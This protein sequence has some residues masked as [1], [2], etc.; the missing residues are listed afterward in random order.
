MELPLS[1]ECQPPL[2]RIHLL[3]YLGKP[4]RRLDLDGSS[5]P[6]P[7]QI[8]AAHNAV[9][10]LPGIESAT[11]RGRWMG[12]SV[13]LEVEGSL[14]RATNL[15]EAQERAGEVESAVFAA[16]HE[17]RR[18]IWIPRAVDQATARR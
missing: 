9:A 7:D 8:E 1:G 2:T 17:A 5:A 3:L 16:V 18:V 6:D 10:Q 14:S 15:A 4:F 11:V 12:R 13:I